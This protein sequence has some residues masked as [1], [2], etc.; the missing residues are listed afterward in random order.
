VVASHGAATSRA[1]E[2]AQAAG[3]AVI[4]FARGRKMNVYTS[5]WRLGL[6]ER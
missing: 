6:A 1:I 4:G 3:I 2:L 5:P